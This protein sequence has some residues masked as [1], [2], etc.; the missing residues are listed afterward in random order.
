LAGVAKGFEGKA[1]ELGTNRVAKFVVKVL[2]EVDFKNA[3]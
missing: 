2:I 1:R 3:A